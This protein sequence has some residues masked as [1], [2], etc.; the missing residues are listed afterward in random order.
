MVADRPVEIAIA[1]IIAAIGVEAVAGAKV[2]RDLVVQACT[3]VA[4]AGAGRR[5]SFLAWPGGRQPLFFLASPGGQPPVPI[6]DLACAAWPWPLGMIRLGI[7]RG[8]AASAATPA[9]IR[10]CFIAGRMHETG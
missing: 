3:V 4:R 6:A 8:G 7:G 9:M 5:S 1:V 10:R 2:V